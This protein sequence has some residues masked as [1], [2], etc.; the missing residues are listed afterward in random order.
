MENTPE[1]DNPET[2]T[3]EKLLNPRLT[4]RADQLVRKS[5]I[6]GG[7]IKVFRHALAQ[8]NLMEMPIAK[9]KK[10]CRAREEGVSGDYPQFPTTIHVSQTMAQELA[11][12][13]K[14]RGVS[15]NELLNAV[16][17]NCFDSKR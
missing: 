7:M 16:I 9:F 8:V 12:V 6:R 3:K 4:M 13:A 5:G 2:G 14:F 1:A 15:M 10:G 11:D 17:I